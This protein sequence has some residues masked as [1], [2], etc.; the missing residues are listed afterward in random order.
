MSY[1]H[2]V[3]YKMV[4]L[5][6]KLMIKLKK[7]KTKTKQNKKNKSIPFVLLLSVEKSVGWRS[8]V[9]KCV[10]KTIIDFGYFFYLS[11][12]CQKNTFS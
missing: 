8:V 12:F 6:C 1:D 11:R 9:S 2:K 3:L 7:T 10:F 5:I 4:I